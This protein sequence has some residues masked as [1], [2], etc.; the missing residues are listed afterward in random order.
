MARSYLDKDGSYYESDGDFGDTQVPRRPSED[1]EWGG[2]AWQFSTARRQ[3]RLDAEREDRARP[4]AEP[5]LRALI[6]E[7]ASRFGVTPAAL[8]QSIRGRL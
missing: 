3:A 8:V 5:M 6:E 2:A 1:H 7:L 4:I